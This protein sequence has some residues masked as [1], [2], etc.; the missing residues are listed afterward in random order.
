MI[1][2]A[3]KANFGEFFYPQ[4]KRNQKILFLFVITFRFLLLRSRVAIKWDANIS[5]FICEFSFSWLLPPSTTLKL[6][7]NQFF[8]AHSLMRFFSSV[9]CCYF[10]L[11]ETFQK[12]QLRQERK[13][14]FFAY[15]E[16]HSHIH[17]LCRISCNWRLFYFAFTFSF[18]DCRIRGTMT[19]REQKKNCIQKTFLATVTD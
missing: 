1:C 19:F 14:R 13:K 8:I 7:F 4:K 11:C 12:Q 16:R 10:F 18:V 9:C 15:A 6:K 2:D 17:F 3:K 5:K